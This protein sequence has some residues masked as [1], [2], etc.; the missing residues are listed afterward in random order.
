MNYDKF[1]DDYLGKYISAYG[2]ECVAEV[3]QY[4]ADNGKPIAWAN[5]KDWA[6]NPALLPAFNW[7]QND[8]N[9]PNQLPPRGAIVVFSGWLPGSGYY[10]DNG[11]YHDPAKGDGAGHVNIFDM[12]TGV[13]SWQGLDA[14][15]GGKTVHFVPN[16]TWDYV[17]GWWVVKPVPVVLAPHPDPAPVPVVTP[18]PDPVPPVV[19]PVV[20]TP[21]VPAPVSEPTPPVEAPQTAPESVVTAPVSVPEDVSAP[22]TSPVQKTTLSMKLVIIAKIFAMLKKLKLIFIGVKK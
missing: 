8:P 20:E 9:D 18:A 2:G 3:S 21:V 10:D 11:T 7:V 15:W 1:I 16:H 17:L 22:T 13:H 4:C 12:V 14:N 6:N 5:A 19:E